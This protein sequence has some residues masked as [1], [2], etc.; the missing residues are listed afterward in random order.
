[1]S[2]KTATELRESMTSFNSTLIEN[3]KNDIIGK[4]SLMSESSA[5]KGEYSCLV[6]L[7]EY[8]KY[9]KDVQDSVYALISEQLNTYGYKH[10][11][12]S[13]SKSVN[14]AI[15]VS[16]DKETTTPITPPVTP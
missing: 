5:K 13:N 16:W 14:I 11:Y 12:T 1:M 9:S 7:T 6:G 8:D 3:I 15:T 2:L 4:I 10:T